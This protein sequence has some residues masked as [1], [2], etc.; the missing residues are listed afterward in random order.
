MTRPPT[1]TTLTGWL[2]D[3]QRHAAAA[4]FFNIQTD[5]LA[6]I[7][8]NGRFFHVNP[9]WMALLGYDEAELIDRLFAQ[10]HGAQ[11]RA[12]APDV[13]QRRKD[14]AAA[15]LQKAR[16]DSRRPGRRARAVEFDLCDSPAARRHG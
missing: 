9:A 3:F 14:A 10:R 5:L 15:D 16:R 12:V 1:P 8:E 11:H 4:E 6:V 2:P 13:C 7:R